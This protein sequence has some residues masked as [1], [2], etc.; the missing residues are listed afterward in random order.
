MHLIIISLKKPQMWPEISTLTFR[1]ILTYKSDV[2]I[3]FATIR[4]FYN[5]RVRAPLVAVIHNND[6]LKRFTLIHS[7]DLTFFITGDFDYFVYRLYIIAISYN[8]R[9]VETKIQ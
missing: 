9:V 6:I 3:F 7:S 2:T 4:Y 1:K 5:V 8:L